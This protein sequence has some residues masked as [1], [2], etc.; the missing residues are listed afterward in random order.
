MPSNLTPNFDV[1]PRIVQDPMRAFWM[2]GSRKGLPKR[3]QVILNNDLATTVDMWKPENFDVVIAIVDWLDFY[4][5]FK[6]KYVMSSIGLGP[7]GPELG[8]KHPPATLPP[9][10]D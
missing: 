3:L 6:D 4:P 10:Q 2:N 1:L 8:H 5:A 9:P 7:D